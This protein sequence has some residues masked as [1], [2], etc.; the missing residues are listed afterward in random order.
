MKVCIIQPAYSTDYSKSDAH[1]AEQLKLMDRC[2]ES[3]DLIV[4]PEATDI[5]CLAKTREDA[6]HSSEKFTDRILKKASETA[7]LSGKEK[8]ST[9]AKKP[10]KPGKLG[11]LSSHSVKDRAESA[12]EKAR[13]KASGKLSAK[14]GEVSGSSVKDKAAAAKERAKEKASGK[15]SSK[16]STA[17]GGSS[18]KAKAMAARQRAKEKSGL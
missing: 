17:P 6:A 8:T 2:N 9:S 7:K 12:R 5:P 13:E 18:V 10:R 16:A 4:L 14:T 15:T 11:R 1:F 3:M